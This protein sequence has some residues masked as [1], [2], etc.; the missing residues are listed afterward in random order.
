MG[1][2]ELRGVAETGNSIGNEISFN[3]TEIAFSS[4]SDSDLNRAYWLFKI[5]E[6]PTVMKVGKFATLAALK[7][8]LP[9][10]GLVK[11]T[12]FKQFCGGETIAECA[13]TTKVLDQ[14]NIGTILDYSVEGKD[15]EKDFEFTAQEILRTIQTGH[16]N[17]HIPFCVFKVSGLAANSLLEKIGAGITLNEKESLQKNKLYERVDRICAASSQTGTPIFIDAEE[18]WI[19]DA[20]DEI[21]TT[22]M[23]RYNTENAVVYNTLQM[24]RHD[25]LEHLKNA[26]ARAEKEGYV[27]AVKLVRGAYMEKERDR[28]EERGYPS[29]IQPDKASTDRDFNLGIEF[30]LERIDRLAFCAGTHNEESS[31][32]LATMITAQN[33]PPN[34]PN[35]FFAQLYGMSDHI[36]F[37]LSDAGFNV[38]KY[39]PYGPV[40]EVMPYLIRRA[41]ENTSVAG[42]TGRELRLIR[43]EKVRRKSTHSRNL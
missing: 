31:M 23:M 22:M 3:N 21:A 16:N 28:A 14:Y 5:L 17:P 41:E 30:C 39:V 32:K 26:Y 42:Q 27:Y 4:K 24:Y 34:H 37:N 6:N 38:A 36:S 20:I 10:D 15:A 2:T 8:R 40:K 43:S 9:I 12:I 29:P 7:L 18:S 13:T 25:R 11:S 33:I 35:I 1:T 19:Q